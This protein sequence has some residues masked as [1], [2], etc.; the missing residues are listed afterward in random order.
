MSRP[1]SIPRMQ[2]VFCNRLILLAVVLV[3]AAIAHAQGAH[4]KQKSAISPKEQIQSL[5]LQWRDATVVGDVVTMDRLLADDYVG[6]T[7]T[8][9]VNT[10]TM[11]LDRIRSGTVAFGKMDLSDTKM[12]I[13]GP[14]A[15]L[16]TRATVTGFSDGV[17]VTG[18]F[19]YTRIYQRSPSGAWKITNSEAT[20][21]PSGE[22]MRHHTQMPAPPT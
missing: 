16:T 4:H 3:L 13:V 18:D 19:R 14:I 2:T 22:R 6:I 17:D 1:R 9:Q 12:K 10:K 15:I 20:Q 11:Q 5:E 7:W 8:G 21:V